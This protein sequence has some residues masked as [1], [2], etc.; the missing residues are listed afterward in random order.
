[1][2]SH[3]LA[4]MTW[5]EYQSKVNSSV[6]ILPV[7]STEQ[8]GPHLPLGVDAILAEKMS[9]AIAER[10]DAVVAPTVSYGYKSLP[11]SGGGPLFPGTVD[12]KGATLTSLVYDLLE[13]FLHDGWKRILMISC[14]YE[15]EAFLA[16]A[17]DLLMRN[18]TAE[19]PK[20]LLSNWWD[21]LS[22]E[23]MPQVFNEVPFP[24][25]ALEHAAIAETSMMMHVAPE[26][27]REDLIVDEGIDNPPSYQ[28][29]PPSSS[30]IPSS[31]C[32]HTARSSSAAKGRLIVENAADNIVAI[33]EK[34]FLV[35]KRLP[36]NVT[37]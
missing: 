33:L 6:L 30:L 10:I 13:E 24:G 31:G 9:L 4:H 14:H 16:E 20:I 34:E 19:F 8:H 23:V 7:G 11:A 27:V 28:S 12:L 25:W 18:R 1:M 2:N 36:N 3:L 32:L 17:A 21:N 15:N 29:F 22:A 5:Q 35:K 37:I 26:L